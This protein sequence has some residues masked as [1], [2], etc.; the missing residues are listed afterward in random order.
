MEIS[1]SIDLAYLREGTERAAF[2]AS[3]NTSNS[4][5]RSES[6]ESKSPKRN[7]PS[8]EK[9]ADFAVVR[10]SHRCQYR[11]QMPIKLRREQTAAARLGGE[12]VRRDRTSQ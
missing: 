12:S 11:A 2:T 7:E 3:R 1:N 9:R 10:S 6:A 5:K 8:G 4:E